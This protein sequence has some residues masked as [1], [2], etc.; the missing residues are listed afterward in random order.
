MLLLNSSR[1]CGTTF[2]LHLSVTWRLMSIMSPGSLKRVSSTDRDISPPAKKR[3]V[4]TATSNTVSNFFK[5]VSEKEIPKVAFTILHETLLI[6]RYKQAN[7]INRPKPVK[8]AAFDF[9]DTL[10][11]SK[12]GSKFAR[13]PD[14][15]KWWNAIVPSRLKELDA[16]GYAL[17]V[18]SNQGAVSLRSDAKSPKDGMKSLTTFKAKVAAVLNALDL[19]ITVYASTGNDP[20]RKPRTG[21]WDQM[22]HDYQL[23]QNGDLDHDQC[24]FVGDAAGREADKAMG[25]KKDHACSDRNLA[26]NVGIPFQTPE[27]YFLHEPPRSYIQTFDP[28]LYIDALDVT[29]SGVL[30]PPFIKKHDTD[31]VLFCGS[32]GAG[33]STFYKKHLQPLGYVRIN[34]DT[35]KSRDKCLKV[36]SQSLQ[37]GVGVTVDNTNAD[38]ETRAAWVALARKFNLPIRLVHFTTPAKLSEHNDAFNPEK[39]VQLPRMAFSSFASRYREPKL[40]EG[41]E[42]ITI[43]DF[44]RSPSKRG[45]LNAAEFKYPAGKS[46]LYIQVHADGTGYMHTTSQPYGPGCR[47]PKEAGTAPSSRAKRRTVDVSLT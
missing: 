34:Q 20:Y 10:I 43:V 46:C 16:Q 47:Y 45:S 33:K 7:A 27:E 9:D 41:F 25:T 40:E 1:Q 28:R 19:P 26:T 32:P 36:A 6:G 38:I 35:L 23:T 5:P 14:D 29:D 44:K 11:T 8:V 2:R 21:M 37:D 18:I 39:R 30:T 24:I 12:S 31:I 13:G 42:D 22:L 4:G 3:I 15:W 17:V